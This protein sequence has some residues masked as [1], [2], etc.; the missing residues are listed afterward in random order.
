MGEEADDNQVLVAKEAMQ[1]VERL[2]VGVV[3]GQLVVR[4]D[5][6]VEPRGRPA[7]E[8]RQAGDHREDEPAMPDDPPSVAGQQP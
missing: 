1:V 3:L 6:D 7:E 2:N 4:V 8:E 5:L